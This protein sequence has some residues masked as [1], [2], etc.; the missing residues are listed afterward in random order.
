MEENNRTKPGQTT[1]KPI[2]FFATHSNGR[3]CGFHL[4][5]WCAAVSSDMHPPV[6]VHRIGCVGHCQQLHPRDQGALVWNTSHLHTHTHTLVGHPAARV[7]QLTRHKLPTDC[8]PD[9]RGAHQVC[10]ADSL[11]MVCLLVMC[12]CVC[13][14]AYVYVC[15]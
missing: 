1:R 4:L 13:V 10:M 8:A 15:I 3:L 9:K 11:F 5:G 7:L 2:F 6:R 14:C 12:V